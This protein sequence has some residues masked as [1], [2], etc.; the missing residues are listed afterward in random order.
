[1]KLE[2]LG[3]LENIKISR[4]DKMMEKMKYYI[5][6]FGLV[7]FAC[8]DNTLLQTSVTVNVSKAGTL[9]SLL[10]KYNKDVIDTLVVTGQINEID[11]ITVKYMSNLS[12]IDLQNT[13][14]QGE[15][16]KNHLLN[17]KNHTKVIKLS[18]DSLLLKSLSTQVLYANSKDSVPLDV[19]GIVFK[20]EILLYSLAEKD[21]IVSLYNLKDSVQSQ[22]DT[23]KTISKKR[24]KKVDIAQEFKDLNRPRVY[25]K[26][27]Q[28]VNGYT[29]KVLWMPYT[30]ENGYT[31]E[32]GNAILYFENEDNHF[33][34]QT[35]C[36]RDT[37]V[38]SHTHLEDG[39]VLFWNYTPK[40]KG[41]ILSKYSPFFFSDVN[42]DGEKELLIN[43]YNGGSRGSNSYEVYKI[44]PYYADIIKEAP[45]ANLENDMTDFDSANK[46]IACHYSLSSFESTTHIYK[47]V[48][49]EKIEWAEPEDSY[50]FE[51]VRVD[52]HNQYTDSKEHKVYIKDGYKYKLVKDEKTPVNQKDK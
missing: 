32:T 39:D 51:L 50:K 20:D 30:D 48:K 1:M 49:Q 17:N 6:L 10:S 37:A 45:F 9:D 11:L 21:C 29:V 46:T 3:L 33:Y 27:K 13:D 43:D 12:Y 22:I 19:A 44:H 38:Y 15:I 26:Y 25:I 28:P 35:K 14:V 4:I 18:N 42:F 7:L 8:N 36:Y 52:I 47:Q 16:V 31:A 40:K 5:L 24:K 2:R 41:E 23:I 34:I